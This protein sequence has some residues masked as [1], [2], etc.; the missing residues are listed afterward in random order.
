MAYI[1]IGLHSK[2][3]K[4][5]TLYFAQN[6][7]PPLVDLIHWNMLFFYLPLVHMGEEGFHYFFVVC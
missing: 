6:P 7:S 3:K 1:M 2:V 4:M 5:G